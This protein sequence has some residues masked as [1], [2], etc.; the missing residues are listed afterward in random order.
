MP[1]GSRYIRPPVPGH[2][3]L[4]PLKYSPLDLKRNEVRL[5][6]LFPD[7][8]DSSSA[9][10][11]ALFHA[12]LI[13]DRYCYL[14]IKNTRGYPRLTTTIII[15]CQVKIV[16]KNIEVFLR[17][18]RS[19]H[20]PLILWIREICIN[21]DDLEE[22]QLQQVSRMYAIYDNADAV[23][24]WLGEADEDSDTAMDF[25]VE[26][27]KNETYETEPFPQPFRS[28][29]ALLRLLSRPYFKRMWVV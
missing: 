26:F 2:A 28:L 4:E 18:F 29:A 12:S 25:V 10:Q 9:V 19:S 16:T 5:L 13:H 3:Y 20:Q 14:A 1:S 27:S 11:C 7:F 21:R 24:I 15:N 6:V 8:G 22:R 17:N 23:I